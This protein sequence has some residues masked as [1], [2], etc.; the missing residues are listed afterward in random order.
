MNKKQI[1]SMVT[2]LQLFLIGALFLP[3]GTIVGD[4]AGDTALSVF[5]MINRYAGM[6]FSD[7]ALFYMVMACVFP[8]AI[9]IFMRVLKERKNFGASVVLC[10]LYAT[11][12]ACFYSAAKRKMVD[13]ATMTWLP[14]IIILISLTSMMLLIFGFFQ[15]AQ[16]GDGRESPKKE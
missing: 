14:Y 2:L 16:D 6:G 5:Q 7:D 1:K 9:I 11:A 10:A 12:S 15:A 13:Y 4:A 3:A 8:A